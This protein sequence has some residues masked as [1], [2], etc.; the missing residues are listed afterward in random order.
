MHYSSP[1]SSQIWSPVPFLS[2]NFM[3]SSFSC[4]CFEIA[5][6]VQF[7][8]LKYAW[9]GAKDYSLR[10][11][12]STSIGDGSSWVS[13]SSMLTIILDAELAAWKNSSFIILYGQQSNKTRFNPAVVA[14]TCNPS[15]W[16]AEAGGSWIWGQ[17]IL[18]LKI[19]NWNQQK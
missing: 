2:S 14:D 3:S 19:L 11:V 9:G 4:F 17:T 8:L 10:T 7:V 15:T 18:C 5:H 16:G 13:P 6:W 12:S 1:N